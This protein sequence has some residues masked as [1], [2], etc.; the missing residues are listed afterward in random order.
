MKSCASNKE[1]THI[2]PGTAK[3]KKSDGT[4]QRVEEQA[5]IF[6]T[7]LRQSEFTNGQVRVDD[8]RLSDGSTRASVSFLKTLKATQSANDR[9]RTTYLEVRGNFAHKGF[10]VVHVLLGFLVGGGSSGHLESKA[11]A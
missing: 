1:Y 2:K 8:S 7:E 9:W 3:Q 11:N 6:A 10:G 4:Y 5:H